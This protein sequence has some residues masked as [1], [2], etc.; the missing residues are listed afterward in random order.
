M[1]KFPDFKISEWRAG[2]SNKITL[3]NVLNNLL[4][5]KL[6]DWMSGFI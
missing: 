4:I 6:D 1:E 2:S 5:G 3:V